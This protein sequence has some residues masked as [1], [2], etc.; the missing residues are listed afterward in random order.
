MG[1]DGIRD[2]GEGYTAGAA[3]GVEAGWAKAGEF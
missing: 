3:G 2:A 1:A